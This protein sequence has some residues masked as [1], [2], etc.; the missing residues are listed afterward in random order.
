MV[1]IQV[2]HELPHQVGLVL[3]AL[4][5]FLGQNYGE[6]LSGIYLYGCYARG[7]FRIDSDIDLLITLKGEVN[8]YE[9]LSRLSELLFVNV[10]S[11]GI[12]P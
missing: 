5:Q 4:R 6:L 8:P 3:T 2:R 11:E 12:L 10:R 7:D 9:E 1:N